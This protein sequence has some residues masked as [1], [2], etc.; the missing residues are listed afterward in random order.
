[1]TCPHCGSPPA[2]GG[3]LFCPHCGARLPA[4]QWVAEPPPSARP[5]VP[6]RPVG[7]YTGPPRYASPPRWGFP[8]RPWRPPDQD[9]PDR[10][11]ARVGV[12]ALAVM[13]VPLLWASAV[14]AVVAAGAEAWR[15][16]LLLASRGGALSAG[17]VAASDALVGSAGVIAPTLALLA[18]LLLVPWTVRAARAAADAAG[19]R[20]SRSPRAI[21]LGWV[22][23]G[24][25]LSVPG[26]VLAE[27]EHAAL[28]RP[29]GERPRPSRLLVVWWVLWAGSVVFAAVVLAWSFREGVQA[30]ADG[31][32]LHA[33]LD[34]L[35]AVTAGVTAVVV[36]RLTRLVGPVRAVPREIVLSVGP[37]SSTDRGTAA[38]GSGSAEG[39]AGGETATPPSPTAPAVPA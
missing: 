20:F 7:R 13:L 29:A 32:V 23:P 24:L 8:A 26:S 35:A 21:V 36:A 10:P 28:G 2:G 30:R 9:A 17:A 15:Y 25:N 31:V 39:N 14:V 11:A 34:L 27:I 16:V 6:P 3:G 4:L 37:R 19:V 18:G 5:V 1:M 22:L 38:A 33:L 12:A